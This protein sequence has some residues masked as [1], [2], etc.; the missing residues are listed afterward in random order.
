ML[1]DRLVLN[2]PIIKSCATNLL[3]QKREYP[4]FNGY[5]NTAI[6]HIFFYMYCLNRIRSTNNSTNKLGM[7]AFAQKIK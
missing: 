1:T 5:S 2:K 6:R 7:S 3:K 4:Q